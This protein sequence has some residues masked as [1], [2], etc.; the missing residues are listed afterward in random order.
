MFDFLEEN[1]GAT[2]EA[3]GDM[4]KETPEERGERH[5]RVLAASL[6]AMRALLDALLPE[7]AS[8]PRGQRKPHRKSCMVAVLVMVT[9]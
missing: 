5:E 8:A 4:H 9:A 3:L 1:M 6:A 2:P 7:K